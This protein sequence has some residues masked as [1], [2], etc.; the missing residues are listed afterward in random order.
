MYIFLD[1]T[2]HL[3]EFKIQNQLNILICKFY[4]TS[5]FENKKALC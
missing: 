5:I 1:F 2:N 3:K 4:T